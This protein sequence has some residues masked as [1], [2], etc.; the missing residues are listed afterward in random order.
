VTS[1]KRGRPFQKFRFPNQTRA[2]PAPRRRGPPWLGIRVRDFFPVFFPENILG[3]PRNLVDAFFPSQ[4]CFFLL[5]NWFF[6]WKIGF[7]AGKLVF[8][9]RFVI[10]IAIPIFRTFFGGAQGRRNIGQFFLVLEN[11]RLN[12]HRLVA[13]LAAGVPVKGLLSLVAFISLRR[14]YI[15]SGR[16]IRFLIIIICEVHCFDSIVEVNCI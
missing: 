14:K 4:N 3:L 16:A 8:L 1:V 6:C 15:F 11:P 10:K 12:I 2:L 7:F 5:G 9:L 13:A